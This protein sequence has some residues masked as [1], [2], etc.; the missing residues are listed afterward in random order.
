[1]KKEHLEERGGD[2]LQPEKRKSNPQGEA[3]LGSP[4]GE[5]AATRAT[6]EGRGAKTADDAREDKFLFQQ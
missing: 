2:R 5:Q 4:M 6:I 3:V 1:M